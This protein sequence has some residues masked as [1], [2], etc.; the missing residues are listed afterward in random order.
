MGQPGE[1]GAL[2]TVTGLGAVLGAALGGVGGLLGIGGGL[3][4]IPVLALWFGM[5]QS[6]AQGTALVMIVPNV[7]L[8]FYRYRQHH[9]IPLSRALG[10][11]GIAMLASYPAARLAVGLDHHTL[12]WVFI[13]FLLGLCVYLCWLVARPPRAHAPQPRV[14]SA[15]YLPVVG[16]VSGV[17]SGLFTVGGGLVAT[18][19]LVRGFG[20][21][22]AAAQGLAL[23]L[24]VPGSLIA[25]STY[26]SAGQVSWSLGLPMAL[27]GLSTISWGVACARRLPER[28]LRSVFIGFLLVTTALMWPV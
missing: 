1:I 17:F 25:L 22:Q 21:R 10:L 2:L 6:M 27:G 3:L 7:L 13:G 16:L 19:M 9:A 5:D 18:P 14:L 8:A 20:H 26:A 15:R 24:V 12:Q 4:A 23:A 28:W 11:G